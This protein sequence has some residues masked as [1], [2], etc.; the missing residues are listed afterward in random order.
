MASVV[1]DEARGDPVTATDGVGEAPTLH[2]NAIMARVASSNA[3]FMSPLVPVVPHLP[4]PQLGAEYTCSAGGSGSGSH[5]QSTYVYDNE[6]RKASDST[7]AYPIQGYAN[8]PHSHGPGGDLAWCNG[9][10]IKFRFW[11]HDV[12]G[13]CS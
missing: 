6:Y 7:W 3:V 4:L 12:D 8:P 11:V 10:N 5:V 2:P 1:A 9:E 13:G